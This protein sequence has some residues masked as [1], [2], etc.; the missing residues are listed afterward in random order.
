MSI[1]TELRRA[2]ATTRAA[3]VAGADVE[4]G[5]SDLKATAR[6]RSRTRVVTGLVAAA[7]VAVLV[8]LPLSGPGPQEGPAGDPNGNGLPG[9]QPGCEPTY[10]MRCLDD[11]RVLVKARTPYT[12]RLPD[13]FAGVVRG[14]AAPATVIVDQDPLQPTSG[15]DIL[16]GMRAIDGS[17]HG[18]AM[19]ARDLALWMAG[20]PFMQATPLVRGRV[21]G[22]TA[23]TQD[24]RWAP[25]AP[26]LAAVEG[27]E[28]QEPRCRPLGVNLQG[29]AMAD[30]G[31]VKGDLVRATY[32]DVPRLGTVVLAS[33][34]IGKH[35]EGLAAND[36]IL[37]SI[38]FRVLSD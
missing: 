29:A 2:A 36:E 28:R 1:D 33:W 22:F 15:A 10:A 20:R 6:R 35:P 7:A 38:D 11:S 9:P 32:L 14:S 26:D 16:V 23:W 4:S 27:C 34:T 12:F 31:V 30:W 3:V 18:K 25:G 37:A 24:L 19:P 5:L 21:D 17:D 8:G 13:G